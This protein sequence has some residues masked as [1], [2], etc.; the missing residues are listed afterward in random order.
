MPFSA[1]IERLL[2]NT[3]DFFSVRT[4]RRCV[5]AR[6]AEFRRIPALSNI[7][8]RTATRK[9]AP[10]LQHQ[11]APARRHRLTYWFLRVK[12]AGCGN[13]H[14]LWRFTREVSGEN[15]GQWPDIRKWFSG[16]LSP[17]S[18]SKN[19]CLMQNCFPTL[20]NPPSSGQ[21]TVH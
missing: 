17:R 9:V 19:E 21:N 2:P 6:S 11:G 14:A 12:N 1:L 13:D 10:G 16:R 5:S 18:A 20:A 8:P 7:M 3:R 4:R 15:A